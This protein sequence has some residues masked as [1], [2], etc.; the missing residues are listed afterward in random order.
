MHTHWK[1]VFPPHG[2][3]GRSSKDLRLGFTLLEFGSMTS[4]NNE[5]VA[6]SIPMIFSTTRVSRG[7]KS[8]YL[9]SR[10]I[11]PAILVCLV[12]Q[13]EAPVKADIIVHDTL[14]NPAWFDTGVGVGHSLHYLTISNLFNRAVGTQFLGDGNPLKRVGIVW[15][16]GTGNGANL[17][18]PSVFQWYFAFYEDP[19]KFTIQ[20]LQT[21]VGPNAPTFSFHFSPTQLS[22]AASYLDVISISGGVENKYAEVDL[23]AL[24]HN[25]NTSVGQNHL[26]FL[27]PTRFGPLLPDISA[28]QALS[29]HNFHGSLPGIYHH[30]NTASQPNTLLAWGYPHNQAAALITTYNA[31]P[32]PSAFALISIMLGIQSTLVRR[33]TSI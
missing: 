10:L 16:H 6:T 26:A 14:S 23:A 15:Q 31:I 30:S 29:N 27:I 33:R 4:S 20:G 24:G 28:A 12:I 17:G 11:L 25:V 21:T 1:S 13:Q 22:N 9:I 5:I 19:T 3:R 2:Q 7:K 8:I 32:E 18:D